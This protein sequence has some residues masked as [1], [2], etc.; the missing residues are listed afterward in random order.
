MGIIQRDLE[1]ITSN[2]A[3][4]LAQQRC[5]REF[6]D[7][8]SYLQ[9]QIWIVHPPSGSEDYFRFSQNTNTKS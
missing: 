6:N 5:G 9:M 1:E 7:L 4:E 2:K 8:P 3:E